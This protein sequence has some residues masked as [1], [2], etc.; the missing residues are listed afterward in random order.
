M[1]LTQIKPQNASFNSRLN[2]LNAR[3]SPKTAKESAVP[4]KPI[5]SIYTKTI[6]QLNILLGNC[7]K[8]IQ[9]E[10]SNLKLITDKENY[11]PQNLLKKADD[12]ILLA[13]H[14]IK[15]II[16]K[17]ASG[18]GSTT[19]NEKELIKTQRFTNLLIRQ[20]HS[21][22]IIGNRFTKRMRAFK[23]KSKSLSKIIAKRSKLNKSTKPPHKI[24]YLS[25]NRIATFRFS[26]PT[27]A[28]QLKGSITLKQLQFDLLKNGWKRG[29]PPLN[30]YKMPDGI[31]TSH[32]NRR[33][34]VLKRIFKDKT[35][36]SISILFTQKIPVIIHSLTE[37]KRSSNIE[38]LKRTL[39]RSIQRER[40]QKT[41]ILHHIQGIRQQ[42]LKLQEKHLLTLAKDIVVKSNTVFHLILL[43]IYVDAGKRKGILYAN[44]DA[45]SK[46]IYGYN[47]TIE[48]S[49]PSATIEAPKIPP[50]P[51]MIMQENFLQ[52]YAPKIPPSLTRIILGN[53]FQSSQKGLPL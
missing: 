8:S 18:K 29:C 46:I 5:K 36:N 53:I 31:I 17:D 43:R 34:K 6:S 44:V 14:I 3:R 1:P 50:Y 27:I 13:E 16:F 12:G 10:A 20:I 30:V 26:H 21:S 23:K 7:L 24:T 11:L 2:V 49:Y 52:F 37:E 9:I 42:L 45:K 40:R 48:R 51:I 38:N 19:L 28:P 47:E 41:P 32:D 33:L 39:K 15:I 22:R 25:L 4:Y 35:E